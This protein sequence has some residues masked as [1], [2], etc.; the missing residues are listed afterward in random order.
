MRMESVIKRDFMVLPY[1]M[2]LTRLYRHVHTT[3][4]FAISYIH[5]LVDHVMIPYTKGKTRRIMIDGKRPHP[6]TPS[7]SSSP[8]SPIPN[9]KEIDLVN[10]YTLDSVAYIDQL[11][12]IL[13]GESLEFKKTKGMF[14]LFGHFLSNPRKTK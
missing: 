2:L 11:P 6:Q 8:P 9:Q 12:P 5:Y 7:K 3:Q 4:P 10:N 14:K 1:G 13:G